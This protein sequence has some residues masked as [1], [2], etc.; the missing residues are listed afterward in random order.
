MRV[1]S[2]ISPR[3]PGRTRFAVAKRGCRG[4]FVG[5]GLGDVDPVRGDPQTPRHTVGVADLS[6]EL[7]DQ[8]FPLFGVIARS[9]RDPILARSKTTQRRRRPAAPAMRRRA[10]AGRRGVRGVRAHRRCPAQRPRRRRPSRSRE[11]AIRSLNSTARASSSSPAVA[12]SPPARRTSSGAGS[13]QGHR[14]VVGYGGAVTASLLDPRHDVRAGRRH[15]VGA[16]ARCHA[17][18]DQERVTTAAVRGDLARR[19]RGRRR[20]RRRSRSHGCG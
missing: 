4:R 3:R 8:S 15:L 2:S 9:G 19:A 10:G 13:R 20:L 5:D 11:S 7:V 17:G 6:W 14:P 18:G 12:G 1:G 16:V